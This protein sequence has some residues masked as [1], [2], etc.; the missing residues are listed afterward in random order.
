MKKLIKTLNATFKLQDGRL[1]GYSES[2][3]IPRI[4]FSWLP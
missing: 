1:L 3:W 4:L 2:A